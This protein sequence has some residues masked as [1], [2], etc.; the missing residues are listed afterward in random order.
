MT[1]SDT[2]SDTVPT[3]ITQDEALSML[4]QHG[5]YCDVTCH[6]DIIDTN[7]I[8][9]APVGEGVPMYNSTDILNWLG[10]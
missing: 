8:V 5:T 4:E 6:D 9:A 7:G 10:Y 1:P 2:Y 3:L